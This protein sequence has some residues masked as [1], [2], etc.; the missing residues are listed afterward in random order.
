MSG[1]AR[2]QVVLVR[3]TVFLFALIPIGWP[4][5]EFAKQDRYNPAL[6]RQETR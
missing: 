4:A 2:C 1:C 3:G 5:A 6:V